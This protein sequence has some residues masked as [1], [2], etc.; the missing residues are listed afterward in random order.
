MEQPRKAPAL[1]RLVSD[2]KEED[3]KVRVLGRVAEKAGNYFVFEDSTGKI[4]VN[5]PA[6]KEELVR[7]FG[8]LVKTKDGLV[9]E[10][11]LIQDMGKIDE[12]VYKSW[13]SLRKKED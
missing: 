1:E 12:K 8:R 6:P 3:I 5:G 7:V 13:M 4:R 11:E 10:P 2:I 9:L